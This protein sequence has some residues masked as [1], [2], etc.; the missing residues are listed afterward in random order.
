MASK[1]SGFTQHKGKGSTEDFLPSR[2][3]LTKLAGGD[4][5]ARTIN[6]YAKATP[7]GLQ[8]FGA[9]VVKGTPEGPK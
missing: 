4:P 1:L 7:T 5:S 9:S 8:T 3:A 2:T 6:N